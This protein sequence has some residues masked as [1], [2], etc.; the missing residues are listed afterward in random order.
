[1]PGIQ[2][3][4]RYSVQVGAYKT[5]AHA[6]EAFTRAMQAGFT[7]AFETHQGL[8]RVLIPGVRGSDM[9]KTAERLY[10]AGFQEIWLRATN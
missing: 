10:K 1:M 4:A 2:D 3:R 9:Q 5:P 7:P 8:I 6:Q